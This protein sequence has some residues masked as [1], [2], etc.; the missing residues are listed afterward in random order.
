MKTGSTV[1]Q[2]NEEFQELK[3]FHDSYIG[4]STSADSFQFNFISRSL[5]MSQ[6]NSLVGKEL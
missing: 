2:L 3:E 5:E 1:Q 4:C 6:V